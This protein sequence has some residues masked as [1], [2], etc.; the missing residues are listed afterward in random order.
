MK[1]FSLLLTFPNDSGP[2]YKETLAGRFPVE[3]FN[4]CSNLLFLVII[5]YF[6]YH[7]YR[8]YKQHLF[9]AFAI[10]ILFIGFIGGSIYHATRSHEIWLLMD[11]IPIMV[12][13]LAVSIYFT[14]KDGNN[15][16]Q[17]IGLLLLVFLL[18]F[19]VRL[20]DWPTKFKI[21]IGYIGT[22]LALLLPVAIYLIKT[23]F[24]N[25]SQILYA[26]GSF[27]LA[28]LFRILDKRLDLFEMGTHWLWHSFGAVAVFF[29]MN[30]I[31][32]D[33]KEAAV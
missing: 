18:L 2:I 21:S 3:P 22:A 20:I 13:C 11:W 1:G 10:P 23:S 9:L 31:F 24:K 32:K 14:F 12:L 19:G 27:S 17:K 7:V 33:K 26:V 8:N 6:S 25:G 5:I 4:T 30:Y 15:W 29:L 28:I 16:L